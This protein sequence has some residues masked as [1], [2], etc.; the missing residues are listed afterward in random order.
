MSDDRGPGIEDQALQ[1]ATGKPS[2]VPGVPGGPN[3]D[4]F[5]ASAETE[6][7]RPTPNEGPAGPRD[8]PD[9]VSRDEG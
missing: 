8:M 6:A 5:D 1:V 3:A 9:P 7:L 4:A 2:Q